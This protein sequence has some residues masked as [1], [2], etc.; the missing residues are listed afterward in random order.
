MTG[1]EDQQDTPMKRSPMTVLLLCSGATIFWILAVSGMLS[2]CTDHSAERPIGHD[3]PAF[4]C[5]VC[6]SLEKNGPFR[7]APNLWGI[8]GAPKAR[9]RSWYSYSHALIEKGGTWTPQELD[10][11]LSNPDKFAPGT[12]MNIAVTD[13]EERKRIIEFL[14]TLKD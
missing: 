7:V 11:F 8:V 2:G 6:H 10:A 9:D 14:E 5:T 4:R 3:S 12:A 13:P 1:N